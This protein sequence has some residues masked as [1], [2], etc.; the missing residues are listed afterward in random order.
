MTTSIQKYLDRAVSVLDKYGI[1][2][3]KDAEDSQ[4]ATL[5][6]DVVNV[7][8]P[9][10]LAIAKTLKYMSSFNELVRDNVSEMN[11]SDRYNDITKMFNSI[12]DDSK[13]LIT[14]L[15][16]GKIDFGEKVQNFWMKLVRGTPHKRFEK[17]LDLY[18]DVSKDTKGQLEKEDNI[19][20][21]YID[22]RFAV[23]DAEILAFN[24]LKTQEVNFSVAKENFDNA[25][26]AVKKYTGTDN[27]EKSRLE[28][29]RDEA[30]RVYQDEDK[31]TQLI[32]DVAENLQIGYN[33]GETLIA[34]LKQTSDVKEQVYKKSVTFFTTNE[35]VF[36]TMDA[37]YTSQHGLNEATQTLESMKEGANKGLEDIAELGRNL[38]RA[39]LKAGYGSTI[40][41]Q[42]V[43]KLV[44]AVVSYQVESQQMIKQ[45]REESTKNAKEIETIVND[46]KQ[47]FKEAVLNYAA[48]N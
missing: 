21:A 6:Q 34:K 35:H 3:A 22:F 11:V 41:A 45:L 16:D 31:K 20:D 43:Q 10:V 47:R 48:A 33:V 5:L 4:L 19:M 44:D 8:E 39:A 38:E 13:K 9:K 36:T 23:K 7:D 24:V 29:A 14:Q 27:E 15:D 1:I 26:N 40:S 28:L 25:A 12:R 18:Q 17:I 46:G 42:S 2:P 37:V 32:K 30:L